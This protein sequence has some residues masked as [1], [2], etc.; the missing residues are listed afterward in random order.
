VTKA[1]S[2]KRRGERG[3][4]AA[5]AEII[6]AS[7]EIL[8]AMA[9][10]T[11]R[12]VAYQLFNRKLIASM[13]RLET[14]RV[15]RIL[16]IARERDEIGWDC[17]VDKGREIKRVATWE[18]PEEIISD[19]LSQYR[20]DF[21]SCQDYRLIVVSEKAT[22]E[23]VIEP[24]TRR[25]GVDFLAVGGFNSSTRMH[26][27]AEEIGGD[28]RTTVILYVGDW[29]PSGMYMSEGDFPGR[30]EEYGAGD[31]VIKRVALTR[32]DVARGDLPAFDAEE[33]KSDARYKWFVSR[34]GTTC[35][36]LDAM[37]PNVLR[38]RVESAIKKYVDMEAWK[39]NEVAQQAEI[40]SI[41]DVL[42]KMR[43]TKSA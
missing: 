39:Q 19:A 35:V 15:S 10:M 38:A 34:Y 6:A 20:K 5:T 42:A 17:I 16:T 26:D 27:L 11:V 37:S 9:P 24:V 41:R 23:G 18:T 14:Q 7:I 12:G 21:W 33:K 29:D 22:M 30:L 2:K 3:R 31:Y 1:S 4:A 13:G 32:A 28:E 8:A 36:E 25:W 40:E 43:K